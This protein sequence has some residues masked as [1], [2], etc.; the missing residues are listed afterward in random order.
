MA[1]AGIPL[2]WGRGGEQNTSAHGGSVTLIKNREVSQLFSD[3]RW[4]ENNDFWYIRS[5]ILALR[6]KGQDARPFV[7]DILPVHRGTSAR[8]VPWP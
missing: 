2:S 1:Q 6:V 8:R 5:N 3:D 7:C 4:Q